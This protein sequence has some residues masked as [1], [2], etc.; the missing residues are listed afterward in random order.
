MRF[1]RSAGSQIT[2]LWR[3]GL[4]PSTGHGAAVSGISDSELKAL[5]QSA[6]L[7]TGYP[8]RGGSSTLYLTT[9]SGPWYDPIFESITA[10]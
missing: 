2:K 7:L 5:R 6:A 9:Q 10:P 8:G 1:R 3:T 4:L